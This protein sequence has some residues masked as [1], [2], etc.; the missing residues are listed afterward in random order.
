M[1]VPCSPSGAR[2]GADLGGA[3][4]KNVPATKPWKAT[5][6]RAVTDC[7]VKVYYNG[8]FLF[9]LASARIGTNANAIVGG[10]AQVSFTHIQMLAHVLAPLPARDA[11]TAMDEPPTT[12]ETFRAL[13]QLT[14]T[15]EDTPWGTI[16][17]ANDLYRDMYV[18]T[19]LQPHSSGLQVVR[20]HV[21]G[22][23]CPASRAAALGNP[24]APA[25]APP[26]STRQNGSGSAGPLGRSTP[27]AGPSMAQSSCPGQTGA[28]SATP[29][30]RLRLVVARARTVMLGAADGRADRRPPSSTSRTASI[31]TTKTSVGPPAPRQ[32]VGAA[33]GGGARA[34]APIGASPPLPPVLAVHGAFA[35]FPTPGT[36]LGV[37]GGCVRVPHAMCAGSP[38][39]RASASPQLLSVVR[40][41]GIASHRAALPNSALARMALPILSTSS[42]EAIAG[43]IG[44]FP[45]E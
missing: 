43:L 17:K 41:V 9:F 14:T 44:A 40:F 39:I 16:N 19:L 5:D 33:G 2:N 29:A 34:A 8:W 7:S 18:P 1:A 21:R 15:A 32:A 13:Q 12:V 45:Q 6:S 23:S 4:S 27:S 11:Q 24:A 38:C 42:V 36:E 31:S 28:G 35:P 10:P 22:T 37:G 25:V 20:H 30:C 3:R 26:S